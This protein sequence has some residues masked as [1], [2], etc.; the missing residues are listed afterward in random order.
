VGGDLTLGFMSFFNN[1]LHFGDG[2]CRVTPICI[3]LNQIGT[4]TN[5]LPHRPPCFLGSTYHLSAGREIGQIRRDRKWE[6]LADG[7][8]PA[9]CDPHAGTFNQSRVDRVPQRDVCVPGT[10]VFDIPHRRESGLQSRT[11]IGRPFE[12]AIGLRFR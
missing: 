6:V 12:S 5:L 3:D 2:Q 9:R 11:G 7:S 8:D 1:D 4:M 10:F